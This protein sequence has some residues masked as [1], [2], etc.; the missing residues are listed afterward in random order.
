MTDNTLTPEKKST[1]QEKAQQQP[2]PKNAPKTEQKSETQ[3][4]TP[5]KVKQTGEGKKPNQTPP[6]AATKAPVK[7]EKKTQ[8]KDNNLPKPTVQ[9]TA[10]PPAAPAPSKKQNLLHK[11]TLTEIKQ[12]I[13]QQDFAKS[14][15]RLFKR[16]VKVSRK[17]S[18][19]YLVAIPW[20]IVAFYYFFIAAP[21]YVSA[22]SFMI[23]EVSSQ[24]APATGGISL[25]AIAGLPS[26]SDEHILNEH[27]L[28]VDMMN[29]L[30]K[31]LQLRAHFSEHP[32]A[33]FVSRL[34]TTASQE[35]FLAY[36]QK[37][38]NIHYSDLS[39]LLTIEIKSYEPSYSKALIDAILKRS[40]ML[41]ND[42]SRELAQAQLDFVQKEVQ[43]SAD[44]L[45]KARQILIRFQDSNKLFNPEQQGQ[46]VTSII[47][48]LEA[49]LAS[50]EA[51]RRRIL[52]YQR[53]DSPNVIGLND[54]IKSLEA[55]IAH[56]N[57][58]L[59]N[60]DNNNEQ[61]INEIYGQYKEL[62]LDVEVAQ[63]TY[64][65]ALTSLENARIEAS[66]KLKHL[67]VINEAFVAEEAQYPKKIY[68]LLTLA[69]ILLLIFG[70]FRM[71]ATTIKEHID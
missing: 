19:L 38:L 54:K 13:T 68:N 33:D 40:E 61:T 10:M 8:P 48:S 43:A 7:A 67:I 69:V 63:T 31:T 29:H 28:S 59:V 2:A 20:L 45:V 56:E 37:L 46:T 66:R 58:R 18:F 57:T 53:A 9:N 32:H 30:D 12:A 4:N 70:L 1:A 25:A 6:Q 14:S 41:V 22:A 23:K 26:Q 36:Y 34:S 52:A 24:G 39:G 5:A 44:R 62:E 49:E 17:K 16:V 42:K 55:Q 35:D 50:T 60:S 65:S 3:S 21:F 64:L 47:S 15:K 27:T 11:S 51:E 71:I